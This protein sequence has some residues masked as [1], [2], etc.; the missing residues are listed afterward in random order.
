MEGR[1]SKPNFKRPVIPFKKLAAF[2]RSMNRIIDFSIGIIH[3][4]KKEYSYFQKPNIPS[5]RMYFSFCWIFIFSINISDYWVVF[6]I[7]R[8]TSVE[9]EANPFMGYLVLIVHIVTNSWENV[10]K[11]KKK[12]KGRHI[13]MW[14]FIYT[15]HCKKR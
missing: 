2:F 13:L 5:K 9:F 15:P 1:N 11:R 14:N 4:W 7:Y 8:Y 3:I 10:R 12:K 6:L